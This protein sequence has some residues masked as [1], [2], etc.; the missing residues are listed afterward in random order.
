MA[1]ATSLLPYKDTKN[2]RENQAFP[3]LFSH[4]KALSR[5][6]ET[7]ATLTSVSLFS[8]LGNI[9]MSPDLTPGA[10]PHDY[11]G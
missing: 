5:H 8:S 6:E 3:R 4:K 9:S 11:L 1:G 7:E 2:N 10:C